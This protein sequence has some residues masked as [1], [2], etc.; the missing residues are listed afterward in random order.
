M[1]EWS[2]PKQR[3]RYLKYAEDN[4]IEV[5]IVIGLGGAPDSPEQ[6]FVVPLADLDSHEVSL[7]DL[8]KYV[9]KPGSYLYYDVKSH[10]LN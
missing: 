3:E 8:G 7:K 10:T 1:V 4:D 6:V 2:N 9:H 5:F